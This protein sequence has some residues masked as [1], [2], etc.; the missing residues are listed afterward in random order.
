MREKDEALDMQLGLNNMGQREKTG[1]YNTIRRK[2]WGSI[3]WLE[4]WVDFEFVQVKRPIIFSFPLL[5]H[6]RILS[7]LAYAYDFYIL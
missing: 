2:D 3:F 6:Q 4:K 5:Y 1:F 7:P